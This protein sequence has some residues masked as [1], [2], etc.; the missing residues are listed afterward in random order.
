M[1]MRFVFALLLSEI[2]QRAC[3]II[4]F[5]QQQFD[6]QKEISVVTKQCKTRPMQHSLDS[7]VWSINENAIMRTV[8]TVALFR[9]GDDIISTIQKMMLSVHS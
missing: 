6:R 9:S 3:P 7:V 8:H 1:K 4:L 2:Q 5:R